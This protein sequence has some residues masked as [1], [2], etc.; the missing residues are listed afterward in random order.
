[1]AVDLLTTNETYFF[2]EPAHF[3]LLEQELPKTA[4]A[5]LAVWS[6]ASVLRRRGLQH[7]DAAGGPAGAGPHHRR[8]VDPGHRHQRPRAAQRER[9]DLPG[10]APAQRGRPQRLRRYCLRGEGDIRGPGAGQPRCAR[11]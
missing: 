6:A 3:E 9:G 8:L 7:G 11:A 1:M 4:E 5:P 2:R 10:G